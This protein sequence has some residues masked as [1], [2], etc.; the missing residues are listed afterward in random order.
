MHLSEHF[1]LEE[2]TASQTATRLGIKN[3]P[4]PPILDNMQRAAK[5]LELV[6][7]LLGCAVLVSSW[8][9]CLRLNRSIGSS[10]TSAHTRGWA[11]DFSSPRF[12][13]PRAI[14]EAI[15]KSSIAFDQLILEGVSKD[16]PHGAWVH[17]SFDPKMRR[18]V[19]TMKVVNG[20]PEYLVG[21]K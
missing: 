20:R 8:Y 17:I 9:R 14:V 15:S 6:R 12:G 16:K 7:A 21:I 19:L 4:T 10:D 11:I 13:T 1:S 18:Q 3:E 5:G 2:A